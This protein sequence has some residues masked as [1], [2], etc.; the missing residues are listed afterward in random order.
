[1][2]LHD[3]TVWISDTH[4]GSRGCQARD[5]VRFLR[6]VQCEK[7]CLVVKHSRQ[8][9]AAVNRPAPTD[10]TR[11][12]RGMDPRKLSTHRHASV[13]LVPIA[14]FSIMCGLSDPPHSSSATLW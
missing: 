13:G 11:T 10:Q 7:L 14:G 4:L 8:L 9:A 3:R 2:K 12:F 6:F 5:L 1:M